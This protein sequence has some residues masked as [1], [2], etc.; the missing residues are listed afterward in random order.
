MGMNLGKYEKKDMII[1]NF[2]YFEDQLN[3]AISVP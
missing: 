1:L 2:T 3:I